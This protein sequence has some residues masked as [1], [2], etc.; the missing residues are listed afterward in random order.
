MTS[1]IAVQCSCTVFDSIVEIL[2]K[3]SLCRI[4]IDH[5]DLVRQV[6]QGRPRKFQG[7][8]KKDFRVLHGSFKGVSR[9]IEGCLKAVSKTF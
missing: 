4:K 2:L 3:A 7:C 1:Y 8:S 9:K 5:F 6:F